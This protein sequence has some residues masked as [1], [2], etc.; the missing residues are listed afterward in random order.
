MNKFIMKQIRVNRPLNI[1]PPRDTHFSSAEKVMFQTSEKGNT[2]KWYPNLLF[3]TMV[4][5]KSV[6]TKSAKSMNSG[7]KILG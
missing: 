7:S 1:T 4:F 5:T 3:A 6:F 2:R